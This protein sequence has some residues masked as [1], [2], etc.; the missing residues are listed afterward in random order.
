MTLSTMPKSRNRTNASFFGERPR[1]TG[2]FDDVIQI[3]LLL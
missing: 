2:K 1:T 3:Y